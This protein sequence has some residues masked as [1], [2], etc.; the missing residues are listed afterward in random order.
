[1][2]IDLDDYEAVNLLSALRSS[3]RWQTH[4]NPLS[5][6]NSGDWVGMVAYKLESALQLLPEND[7]ARRTEFHSTQYGLMY[8]NNSP[9]EYIDRAIRYAHLHL[10][11]KDIDANKGRDSEL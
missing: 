10:N 1:M 6:I 7:P 2:L 3:I 5:V 11:T 9:D 8:P 4:P